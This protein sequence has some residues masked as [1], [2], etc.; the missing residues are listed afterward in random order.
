MAAEIPSR[1]LMLWALDDFTLK[2]DS[3]RP[4]LLYSLKL[5]PVGLT[6]LMP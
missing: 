6:A 3:R 2:D 4:P 5:E 1:C